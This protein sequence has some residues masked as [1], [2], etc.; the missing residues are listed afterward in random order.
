MGSDSSPRFDACSFNQNHGRG[1]RQ[2]FPICVLNMWVVVISIYFFFLES[3]GCSSSVLCWSNIRRGKQRRGKLLG[4]AR[5]PAE[6]WG[7]RVWPQ[8]LGPAGL[9]FL[10][11]GVW[12]NGLTWP[13][14]QSPDSPCNQ[15]REMSHL[16]RFLSFNGF[17]FKWE[18]LWDLFLFL[19]DFMSSGDPWRMGEVWAAS[20]T[21]LWEPR[22]GIFT[23]H[24]MP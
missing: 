13:V 8:V 9:S 10:C 24:L 23:Q 19:R 22:S 17:I 7:A 15:R 1:K 14:N 12:D 3:I 20:G 2:W 6:V 21:F 11:M 16:P 18:R 4:C 5:G